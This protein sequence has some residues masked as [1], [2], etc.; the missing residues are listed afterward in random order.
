MVTGKGSDVLENLEKITFNGKKVPVKYF[1]KYANPTEKPDYSASVPEG[2][3]AQNVLEKYIEAIGGKDKLEDVES[4]SLLAEAEMQGMILQL[5]MKKTSK[6]Q[7]MQ[8]VKVAG[9]SMSKQVM[10]GNKGYMVMQGQRKD[11]SEEELIKVKE[12]SAPFPELN[13]LNS[14]VAL[15]GV[16]V[17]GDKKAYKIKITDNKTNFYDIE[18]GLKIQEMNSMEM[19]GQKIQQTLRYDDYQEVSGIKFPFKLTQSMGPQ[20]MDFMVKEI[21]VN[22]GVSDADFE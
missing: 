21:K 9:N 8:D 7:F 2:L 3:T 10:D 15:E 12:E 19:Q 16:E 5:D 22:E 11:M 6:D 17:V 4:Y 20:S 14:D 13:Y 1:D 18:T